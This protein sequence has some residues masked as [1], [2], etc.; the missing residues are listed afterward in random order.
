MASRLGLAGARSMGAV[1]ITSVRWTP[2]IDP[3]VRTAVS[4]ALAELRASG[5]D[6]TGGKIGD[7]PAGHDA[8]G[9]SEV[10]SEDEA[11]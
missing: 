1:E 2:S 4:F 5:R 8:G 7:D 9:P 3:S 11:Y 6:E 10:T